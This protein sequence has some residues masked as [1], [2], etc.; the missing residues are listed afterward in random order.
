M[1][2]QHYNIWKFRCGH[3]EMIFETDEEEETHR[4]LMHKAKRKVRERKTPKAPQP[5]VNKERVCN[6]CGAIVANLSN[7][8]QLVHDH[9]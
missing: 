4:R 3:C 8:M 6:Q 9:R 1:A 7:H 2:E 5:P